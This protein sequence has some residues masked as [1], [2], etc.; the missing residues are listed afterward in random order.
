MRFVIYALIF[1]SLPSYADSDFGRWGTTC[2]GDGFV[3]SLREPLS[4]LEVNEDQIVIAVH[5]KKINAKAVDV[6]FDK[7]LALERG[8]R[9]INWNNIDKTVKIAEFTYDGD[10]HGFLKW[11]GF[12]DEKKQTSFWV[13][14]PDFVQFYAKDGVIEMTKCQGS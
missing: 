7:P 8:G 3:L 14:E 2:D 11:F 6:Y 12:R 10:R 4:V 13:T 1:M 5:S 9:V